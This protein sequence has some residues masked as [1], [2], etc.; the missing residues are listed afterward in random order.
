MNFD[1]HIAP[2]TVQ[3][4]DTA[5]VD[6]M[7]DREEKL[8]FVNMMEKEV[9][10]D[11]R[12]GNRA[13][14]WRLRCKRQANIMNE[15]GKLGK[16]AQLLA[17]PLLVTST[18][19]TVNLLERHS[20]WRETLDGSPLAFHLNQVQRAQLI[21]LRAE[22]WRRL[23]GAIQSFGHCLCLAVKDL[24]NP[25]I[26][27]ASNRLKITLIQRALGSD[28]NLDTSIEYIKWLGKSCQFALLRAIPPESPG[29]PI[30]GQNGTLLP[31]V[32][33]W[34]FV[35]DLIL[36]R[37]R[38]RKPLTTYQARFL[39]Q[40]GNAPRSLP[41]P[42]LNQA[43]NDV[44]STVEA[45][46][47]ECHPAKSAL[48][49]YREG[50]TSIRNDIG[51][52]KPASVHVSLVSSGKLDASRM[53]GGG[54]AILV[55]HTRKYTDSVLTRE[56]L[57]KLDGKYDQFGQYLIDPL[58]MIIAR[59]LLGIDGST[60]AVYTC[61]P[62]IGDILY[63][64]PE[65]I[66][67]VWRTTL[68]SK[69]RVPTKLAQL[70]T[71]TASK[72]IMEVGHYDDEPEIIEN[73][74]TFRKQYV[75]FTPKKILRVKAGI[76]LESG[77]KSRIT[78]SGWAAFAHLSQLPANYMRDVLTLDPFVKVGFQDANKFWEVLKMYQKKCQ[79][80]ASR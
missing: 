27:E 30:T 43:K 12:Q 23:E 44:K 2:T 57:E 56:L 32:G 52:A 34:S 77:L 69:Q 24:N 59:T 20:S 28:Q 17:G 7:V 61:H 4:M 3:N 22:P 13:A 8:T 70:L 26:L 5:A 37:R 58:T 63:L 62:T 10:R 75:T 45:F 72:L 60:P 42:S 36:S 25:N 67:T 51:D 66:E 14:E 9:H 48:D 79:T 6:W 78:T 76:S 35:S 54:A 40:I 33:Q 74:M 53:K 73:I 47:S 68:N 11:L 16:L 65:E 64:K 15:L 71:L 41:H 18:E 19:G 55:G 31:F 46:T 38:R 29:V 21:G 49:K 80:D 39:G 1:G 50:I